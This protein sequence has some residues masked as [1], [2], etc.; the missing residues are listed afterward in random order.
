M[1]CLGKDWNKRHVILCKGNNNKNRQD[2]HSRVRTTNRGLFLKSTILH[3]H[4]FTVNH[5][6]HCLFIVNHVDLN[7]CS[8]YALL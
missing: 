8:G 6:N 3:A 2:T 1:H 5:C 4:K 7:H